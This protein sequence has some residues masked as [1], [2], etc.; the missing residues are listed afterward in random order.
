MPTL[1]TLTP[2]QVAGLLHVHVNTVRAWTTQYGDVLSDGA[3][4]RPRLLSPGDV[5]TLQLVQ[6][7]HADGLTPDETLQR[8]RETPPGDRQAPHVDSTATP[9]ESPTETPTAPT[10]SLTQAP[11]P[12]LA[13]LAALLRNV[14]AQEDIDAVAARVARLETRDAQRNTQRL[15][16]TVLAV[17]L[18]AGVAVGVI[19][20]V[21]L[22]R[23]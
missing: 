9:T 23:L 4:S 14:P 15:V 5:A 19:L 12:D 2:A 6:Q 1:D 11:S 22:L 8:L 20:A 10:A 18:V 16:W 7:L 3:R 21:L 17:G 13:A